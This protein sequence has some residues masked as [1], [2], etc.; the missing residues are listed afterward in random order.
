MIAMNVSRVALGEECR[1]ERG[2]QRSPLD[3]ALG[4]QGFEGRT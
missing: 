1:I 2:G 4:L 3:S